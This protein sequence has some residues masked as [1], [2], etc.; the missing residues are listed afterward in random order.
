MGV[1]AA[2]FESAGKR[3]EHYVPGVYSRQSNTTTP[4]GIPAG[5][6]CILGESQGGKPLSLFEFG[7]LQEA[8]LALGGG[9][10][11]EGVGFAFNGSREYIPQR[12]FA[13]RVNGGTQSELVLKAGGTDMI[14]IKSWDW[15][16]QT[17]QLK[18]WV[19]NGSVTGS[20]TITTVYR[21][22]QFTTDNII[23][24]SLSI[25]YIGDGTAPS[26][27]ISTNG[28][29][30]AH[31]PDGAESPESQ[32]FSF[33][34]Y[35][36]LAILAARINDTGLFSATVADTNTQA[37]SGYLDTVSGVSV[38]DSVTFYSNFM[39]FVNELKKN[40]Y[41]GS[42]ELMSASTRTMP[43]ATDGFEYFTGGT[44]SVASVTDYISALA[45]LETQD[46]QI[47]ATPSTDASVHALIADHCSQMCSTTNRKERTCIIGGAIG[48]SDADAIQKAIGF[49]SSVVSYVTDSAVVNSPIT[50]E[51][52]TVP[53]SVVAV[54]LAGMEASM[55]ANM[56]LTNKSLNVLGFTKHRTVTN[57]ES[58]IKKGV[59]VCN[60]DP[61]DITRMVC[62]RALTTY[63]ED[64]LIF[65]ER[66]MVREAF[67]MNR[68]LRNRYKPVIGQPGTFST[69]N[70]AQTLLDIAKEWAQ[71][72]YIIPSDSNQN[73][74]DIRVDI[75][76]DKIYITYSRYLTSPTNF[77][78][79]TANNHVYTS[80]QQI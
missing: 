48:E 29:T 4:G 44:S 62:I 14:K 59:L 65:N 7:T 47:I 46:I 70:I 52:E 64:D 74:W 8:R 27:T 36:T 55:S 76:G 61:E 35:S 1:S 28:I 41:V 2:V 40:A 56:P 20:K 38:T 24:P 42:V 19:K 69:S 79:I 23:Q 10:L 12:V 9:S 78:F 31:T 17:N 67:L 63:Q 21:E 43:D 53:G 18:M 11:L 49:N 30:L 66:S 60:Y 80:T 13:M 58:L 25:V 71:K 16:A 6:L 77:V 5:N 39:T 33:V 26:V 15:G 68:E 72:G 3:T 37:P 50:G 54:M 22:D 73:V 57:M 34:D 32:M 51:K 45:A 75:D